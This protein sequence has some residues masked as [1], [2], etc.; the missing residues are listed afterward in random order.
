MSEIFQNYASMQ[1]FRSILFET[2][3]IYSASVF[4]IR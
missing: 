1:I 3:G 2:K 4:K